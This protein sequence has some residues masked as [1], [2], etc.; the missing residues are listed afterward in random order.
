M[1]IE[2]CKNTEDFDLDIK[3]APMGSRE[4]ADNIEYAKKSDNMK[5]DKG[6]ARLDLLPFDA[7]EELSYVLGFG[8]EKYEKYGWKKKCSST[9]DFSRYEASLLRH[10]SSWMQ[11]NEFDEETGFHELSHLCCNALFLLSLKNKIDLSELVE[12]RKILNTKRIY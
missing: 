1:R 5:D 12:D 3:E 2:E 9:E 11:G 7:L 10:I 8:A 6:K 4:Y